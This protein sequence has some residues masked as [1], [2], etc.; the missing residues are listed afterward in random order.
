MVQ[1][2]DKIV[3]VTVVHL[4]WMPYGTVLFEKFITSYCERKAG[5]EHQ[6]VLLFNGVQNEQ[7]LAPYLAIA[8][9]NKITYSPL[10]HYGACQDIDA[11]FWAARQLNTDYILFLNSYSELQADNW[12]ALYAEKMQAEKAGIIGATG[13]WQ[14]YSSSVF[15]NNTWK[16]ELNKPFQENFSKFKLLLKALFYWSFLFPSFPNPHIRTNAFMLKR[17]LLLSCKKGNLKNKFN[18]YLFESGRNSLTRQVN[19]KG[20]KVLLIDKM[21]N[22]YEKEEWINSSTFWMQ[23][24]QNL[25]VADNQTRLYSDGSDAQKKKLTYLAWG[26]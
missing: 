20:L 11:Y 13:S 3:P 24:Q 12:L 7:D 14:S 25:L 15:I 18:A 19:K 23:S 16:W 1:N 22:S 26:K 17:A 21:G 8:N 4:I 6:L 5:Y 9:A 10:I 2:S